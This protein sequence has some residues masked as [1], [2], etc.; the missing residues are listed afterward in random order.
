MKK[1]TSIFLILAMLIVTLS[2]CSPS[3]TEAPATTETE[4]STETAS[5]EGTT[6][7]VVAAYGFAEE[8]FAEF[9]K[10][11]GVKVEFLDMSS[12]EVLTR[13][14]AEGGKPMADV[15]F[16]GGA[17]SFMVAGEKGLLEDYVSEEEKSVDEKYRGDN[18][19]TGISLVTAGFMVNNDILAEKGLEAPKTWKDLLKPEYKDEIAMSDPAISGTNYAVVN[20]ILQSMGEEEGWAYLEELNKNIP[21]YFQ[22]GGEPPTKVSAGEMAIGVIPMSGEFIAMKDKFPVTTIYPEDGIPWV[23]AG[24]AI[25]KNASNL[26]AAKAFVDWALSAKGQEIIR[27]K[28]PRVMV[29]SD[30]AIPELMNDINLDKLMDID[31]L[32]FSSERETILERWSTMVGN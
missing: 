9:T 24:L 14:E 31:L 23:P 32:K 10:D 1:F 6:M 15:W 27:D 29:R 2:G 21:F 20:C 26:D 22:R 3:T 19:W 18:F 7:T 11:T 16:G 4:E 5:I 28:D 8:I 13:A 25:F 12:G 17:D 30:V